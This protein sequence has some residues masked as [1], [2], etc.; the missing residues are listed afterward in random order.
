[1]SKH[2]RFKKTKEV[3]DFGK[4]SKSFS[5]TKQDY[6]IFLSLLDVIHSG[7]FRIFSKNAYHLSRSHIFA[8]G[9]GTKQN[10]PFRYIKQP[11]SRHF[12]TLQYH[13]TK[14]AVHIFSKFKKTTPYKE[15]AFKV[16]ML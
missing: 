14:N 8:T 3:S 5:K 9:V 1:M 11:V 16:K 6:S 15:M 13:C 10:D 4:D 7:S 2:L 12:Q